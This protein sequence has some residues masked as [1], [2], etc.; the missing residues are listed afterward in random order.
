MLF[1]A[2]QAPELFGRDQR[3]GVLPLYFSRVLTSIDYALA[4]TGGLFHRDPHRR[5][6]PA[7]HPEHR[8]HPGRSGSRH[9]LRD[10]LPEI[11]SY[12]AGA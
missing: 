5:V 4:R 1:C 6:G 7:S 11:P 10:E 8:G 9:R 12:L 3:Y 2:A